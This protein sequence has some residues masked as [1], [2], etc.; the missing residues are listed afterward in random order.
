MTRLIALVVC[1][2]ALLIAGCGDRSR[3][4]SPERSPTSSPTSAA[5]DDLPELTSMA[6]LQRAF[7]A[8]PDVP[9]LVILLSPT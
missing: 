4:S 6:Q 1:S 5:K 9:R 2:A 8:H 3:S 7:D